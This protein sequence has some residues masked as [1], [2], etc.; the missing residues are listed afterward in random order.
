[1]AWSLGLCS[2]K[3]LSVFRQR[4]LDSRVWL[5]QALL[6]RFQTVP[7]VHELAMGQTTSGIHVFHPLPETPVGL[8]FVASP[9]PQ[10]LY[11]QTLVASLG[12]FPASL[13][14]HPQAS[15]A[16]SGR[17]G[18]STIGRE[19]WTAPTVK[20]GAGA[21]LRPS[22]PERY[23]PTQQAESVLDHRQER[24]LPQAPRHLDGHSRAS[25]QLF[26]THGQCTQP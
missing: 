13:A 9:G 26:A 19:L 18:R 22:S 15:P 16:S 23:R 20:P 4:A 21:I 8:T 25:S 11:A 2:I 10:R 1:M 12:S 14:Q 6:V 24:P 17:R 3:S 7:A 5:A